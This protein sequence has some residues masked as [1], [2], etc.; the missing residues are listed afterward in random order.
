MFIYSG[1]CKTQSFRDSQSVVHVHVSMYI[2]VVMFFN[3]RFEMYHQER[4]KLEIN[5]IILECEVINMQFYRYSYY[6]S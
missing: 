6:E 1:I 2:V 3:W 4:M 5:R